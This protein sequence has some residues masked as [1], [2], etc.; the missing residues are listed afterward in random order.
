MNLHIIH[1]EK[2]I[3]WAFEIFEEVKENQNHFVLLSSKKS[4]QIKFLHKTRY[5]IL[6][7]K[8]LLKLINNGKYGIV[9]VHCLTTDKFSVVNKITRE[10]KIVWLGWGLDYYSRIY[11]FEKKYFLS[12]TYSLYL[13]HSTFSSRLK[14]NIYRILKR[15]QFIKFLNR[16]TFFSPV[17]RQDYDLLVKV[18]GVKMKYLP[19]NYGTLKENILPKIPGYKI[20]SNDIMMGNSATYSNN[21]LD[22]FNLIGALVGNRKII[23][24]LSYGDANYR[25]IVIEQG[26]KIFGDKFEAISDFMSLDQYYQKIQIC[27]NVFFGSLRQQGLGN[28]VTMMYFGAK[29]FLFKENPLYDFFKE[30]SAIIFSFDE[31]ILN[32]KILDYQLSQDDIQKNR[33]IL[34]L[35]WSREAIRNKT[36]KFFDEP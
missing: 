28:I 9:F 36:F 21:H 2:F 35:I 14:K 15:A 23:C 32:N 18:F 13:R 6:E 29:I 34:E 3:D 33:Q 30:R 25:E 7:P 4:K 1:D 10:V 17:I 8:A 19:W 16:V 26:Q 31:L 12:A 5:T 20:T 24:P 11:Q 27:G 22:V